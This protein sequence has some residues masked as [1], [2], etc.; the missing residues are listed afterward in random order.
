MGHT[1]QVKIR[2][3]T[4]N[5][6]QDAMSRCWACLIASPREKHLLQAMPPPKKKA[7]PQK[8]VC[9]MGSNHKIALVNDSL[10]SVQLEGVF[11][12]SIQIHLLQQQNVL[13]AIDVLSIIIATRGSASRLPAP[14]VDSASPAVSALTTQVL[15]K[16]NVFVSKTH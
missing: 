7:T 3:P 16:G 13:R 11:L 1:E 8:P 10:G 4:L 6:A 9:G 15:T 14:A 12:M 5:S 2:R